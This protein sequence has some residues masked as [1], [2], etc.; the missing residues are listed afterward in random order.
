MRV[1]RGADD[2]RRNTQTRRPL[3][4][5]IAEIASIRDSKK[6][7]FFVDDNITSNLAQAK[8]FF[9]AL[10]PLGIRWVSQSSINAAH[11]EEFLDLLARSGCQG[12]LIGFE[13]LNPAALAAMN[14][15][16]NT[17]RGGYEAAL[18]NLA[19]HRLRLY[20]T[21]IFGYDADTP[22]S[23]EHAVEFAKAHK[24]YIAAFNHLTPF[25][26]TPLYARLEA[27]GPAAVRRW[28]L[29]DRY[30]YNMVP[31]QAGGH[32]SGSA[33]AS[34]ASS[35]GAILRLVEHRPPRVRRGEPLG[36][37]HVSQLLPDQQHA[38]YRHDAP[39]RVSAGRRLVERLAAAR[40]L[41]TPRIAVRASAPATGYSFALAGRDDDSGIRRLL[42]D[43]EF[44][45]DV[46]IAFEREPDASERWCPEGGVHQTIVA[47]Q[48][49]ASDITAIATRSVRQRF[50]N[51]E[52]HPVGYL[53]QLR[54]APGYRRHRRLLDAGFDYCRRLH[55]DDA[56]R[57][58]LASVVAD[59]AA[60]LKLLSRQ[61]PG[62]PRFRPVAT[63]TTLAI[64]VRH[65]RLP[66]ACAESAHSNEDVQRAIGCLLRNGPRLQFSPVWTPMRS[67][68]PLPVFRTTSFVSPSATGTSLAVRRSG[69]SEP[70]VR[71]SSAVTAAAG[72]VE[73]VGQCD[74]TMDR[75]PTLPPIGRRLEF[76]YVSHLAVDDDDPDVA[77][78]LICRGVRIRQAEGAGLRRRGVAS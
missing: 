66:A 77:C 9:R 43:A 12:V 51:G 48:G 47:R 38:A 26:G 14:K 42:R 73:M 39:R 72:D 35:R 61:A 8:E 64:P 29:D 57:V 55:Q 75:M 63:L 76:G 40:A 41:T 59:N 28:W 32:G 44:P 71:S 1:L 20:G 5:I 46:R 4:E 56:A 62:W 18:A 33:S 31:F 69:I 67:T 2:V 24:F 30:R 16:F 37:V 21:F 53:S 15:S 25:P 7:F 50:V 74:S 68:E 11:D 13:S 65:G 58:Y 19:T 60:A 6:L 54:I 70:F 45:G 36:R 34:S 52:E 17:M 10:I 3:D 22:E 23:F 27:A 49:T 78:A